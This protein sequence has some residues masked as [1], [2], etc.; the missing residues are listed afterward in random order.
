MRQR[1]DHSTDWHHLSP[2]HC[3]QK[4]MLPDTDCVISKGVMEGVANPVP[5]AASGI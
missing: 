2:T 4:Q 5:E 1:A 3:L